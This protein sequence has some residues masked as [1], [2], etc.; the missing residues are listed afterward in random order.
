[1][2]TDDAF[3][4]HRIDTADGVT[5]YCRDYGPAD[6]ASTPVLC[7]HGLT[8]NSADFH[9]LACHLAADTAARRR[10]LAPDMRGRGR[11]EYDAQWQRYHP[12]TYRDDVFALIDRLRVERVVVI[13]TSMGGLIAMLMAEARPATLAGVVLNDVGPEIAPEGLARILTYVGQLP[14]VPDWNAAA[15]QDR[16][17]FEQ[18]LPDFDDDDW[19]AHARLGYTEDP[20]GSVRLAAD[21]NVGRALREVGGALDDPW[22]LF[23]GL[24]PIPTLAMRGALSDILSPDILQRMRDQHPAMVTATIARRGHVPLLDEADS[25]DAIDAFLAQID[26]E[27]HAD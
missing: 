2:T 9:D 21:P 10:V 15:A 27:E 5:L 1:M 16:S 11:S 24:R 3:R 19:L 4:E 23:R 14:P 18:A 12:L 13:G 7:L 22:D 25:L 6:T 17:V 20:D 26:R 8:R